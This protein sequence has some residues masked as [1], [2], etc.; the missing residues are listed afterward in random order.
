MLHSKYGIV[1]VFLLFISPYLVVSY[2]RN[3]PS[4]NY[5]T[6]LEAVSTSPPSAEDKH[7]S[8]QNFLTILKQS[9]V[10]DNS[11]MYFGNRIDLCIKLPTRDNAIATSFISNPTKIIETTWDGSKR[12]KIN[13]NSYLLKFRDFPLP[14]IDSISPEIEVSIDFLDG[15]LKMLSKE[16]KIRSK[17]GALLKDSKF[18]K[19]FDIKLVGEIG[20]EESVPH[21]SYV[22]ARG[23]VEYK[24]Q[25]TK[26]TIFRMAPSFVLD[27]TIRLIQDNVNEYASKEFSERFLKGFRQHLLKSMSVQTQ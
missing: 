9:P 10:T 12:T 18:M 17:T 4:P 16:W 14:G 24:V 13:D 3:F 22:V 25:G 2:I 27:G 11:L 21:A 8:L 20:I 6:M 5:R 15:K 7:S 23:W 1:F 19:K 26:P